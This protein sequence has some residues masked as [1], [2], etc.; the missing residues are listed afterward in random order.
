MG[1]IL[2]ITNRDLISVLCLGDSAEDLMRLDLRTRTNTKS[3]DSKSPFIPASSRI[4]LTVIELAKEVKQSFVDY[5]PVREMLAISSLSWSS[6]PLLPPQSART[7]W[8][9]RF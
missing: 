2:K 9:S 1:S 5:L 4:L 3:S 8:R 7:A 6:L